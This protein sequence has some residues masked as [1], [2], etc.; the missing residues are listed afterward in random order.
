MYCAGQLN[1]CKP[2][3][4]SKLFFQQQHLLLLFSR[5]TG[6]QVWPTAASPRRATTRGEEPTC[7]YPGVSWD[8]DRR[9]WVAQIWVAGTSLKL[10]GFQKE[11]QAA[12]AYQKALL[13]VEDD[14]DKQWTARGLREASE[15][16]AD[17]A[18]KAL[19][20]IE[21]ELKLYSSPQPART[22]PARRSN[23][24]SRMQHCNIYLFPEICYYL[25]YP[26][27]AG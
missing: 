18:L 3:L 17:K 22:K 24:C 21:V 25:I 5:A 19:K 4:S 14:R 26:V 20:G 9:Q 8:R 11:V 23:A 13:V 2:L 27:G 1:A 7:K 10:G 15:R 6:L 12:L 16:Y